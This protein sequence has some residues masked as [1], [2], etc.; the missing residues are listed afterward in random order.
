MKQLPYKQFPCPRDLRPWPFKFE[1]N[2]LG[3]RL[4]VIGRDSPNPAPYVCM[5]VLS[6]GVFCLGGIYPVWILVS[7][8]KGQILTDLWSNETIKKKKSYKFSIYESLSFSSTLIKY[9]YNCYNQFFLATLFKINIVRWPGGAKGNCLGE[10]RALTYILII[11]I[12]KL[13]TQLK[14]PERSSVKH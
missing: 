3:E 1:L 10:K 7:S 5:R 11:S 2:Y 12:P 13:K 8:A 14:T 4:A 9:I 6:F